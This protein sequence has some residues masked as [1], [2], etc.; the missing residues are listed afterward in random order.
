LCSPFGLSPSKAICIQAIAFYGAC[1]NQR[2]NRAPHDS[3]ARVC[4]GLFHQPAQPKIRPVLW[5]RVF[6]RAACEPSTTLLIAV[7]LLAFANALVWH[8]ALA[9]AFSTRAVQTGYARQRTVLN[10][11]AAL[12]M[13]AF[14]VRLL[15]STANELRR[16]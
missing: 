1:K 9:F 5:Q 11:F 2:R 7:V 4:P 10:R 12:V 16:L 13:G 3:R 6:Y 15:V 8:L 14:G